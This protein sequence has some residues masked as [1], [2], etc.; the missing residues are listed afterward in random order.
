MATQAPPAAAPGQVLPAAAPDLGDI[1]GLVARSYMV[2]PHAYYVLLQ[3]G[4]AAG[5]RRWLDAVRA[6]V[7]PAD[8]KSAVIKEAGKAVNLAFTFP[9]LQAL[10]LD[11][12]S[13]KTFLREFQEGM[14]APHR[15]RTLGDQP[16]P[17]EVLEAHPDLYPGVDPED[18]C[19]PESEW[20]WGRKYQPAVHVLLALFTATAKGLEDEYA[21]EKGRWEAHGIR[22]VRR[23]DTITLEADK[24]HFG[25]HDGIAQPRVAGFPGTGD[26]NRMD[27]AVNT[28]EVAL[29]YPNA[30]NCVPD[31]PGVPAERDPGGILPPQ[32]ND[33]DYWPAHGPRHDLGANGSYVVLRQLQQ[34]VKEFWAYADR[35]A[36]GQPERR[37]LLASKIVG[38]WPNGAPLIRYP[39][40]EPANYD[41]KRD[42]GNNFLYIE[43]KDSDPHGDRCPIGSHIRRSNPRD[44]M[45]PGPKESLVVADRHRLM[46]RGRSYGAPLAPSFR[47]EDILA[48][49]EGPGDERGLHFI[50]FNTDLV[51]QFEFVQNTWVNNFKFE[52]LYQDP[53]ALVAAHDTG[54]GV[55][56]EQTSNFTDQGCPFRARHKTLPR[57]VEMR[58]GGYFFMPGLRALRY[59]AS[60]K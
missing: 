3:F 12:T 9:G 41:P 20:A 8:R 13:L 32:A 53:D 23:L 60:L 49:S 55:K 44:S 48:A 21:K 50:C 37:K 25:F 14:D 30:Y 43:D 40:E 29:G 38:R 17:K 33:P 51:R 31:S 15:W 4:D 28:G 19:S 34:N 7:T 6:E 35:Q 16:P 59:L 42:G 2:L 47:P 39:G 54:P 36:A 1:Q 57:F 27:G 45:Q 22:E 52:G 46:R 56:P 24:E 26:P 10:G 58:G 5:A 18:G 11:E